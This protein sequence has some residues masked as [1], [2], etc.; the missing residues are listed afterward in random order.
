MDHQSLLKT[1]IPYHEAFAERDV[2]LRLELLGRSI[3][4]D[5]EIWGPKRVFAGYKA[6]F[7]D[8]G[9]IQRVLPLW[10]VLPPL[11]TGWPERFAPSKHPGTP[12]AAQ[13][14]A[15]MMIPHGPYRGLAVADML[16]LASGPT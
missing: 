2:A 5:A 3:T 7:A 14:V 4:P 9:R 15:Q 11:P 13:P 8:D 10:E 12:S 6:I 16:A 1:L